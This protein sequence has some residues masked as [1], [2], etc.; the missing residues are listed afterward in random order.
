MGLI[1]KLP[2]VVNEKC[3]EALKHRKFITRWFIKIVLYISL[4]FYIVWITMPYKKA[5]ICMEYKK[6]RETVLYKERVK[7][8]DKQ[9]ALDQYVNNS[10]YKIFRHSLTWKDKLKIIFTPFSCWKG[11]D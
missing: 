11:E 6:Y 5:I 8:F 3:G 10:E 9:F 1:K 7:V 2:I 4:F